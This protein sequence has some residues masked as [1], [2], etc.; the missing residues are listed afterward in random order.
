MRKED[1]YKNKELFWKCFFELAKKE[2]N[3][4]IWGIK[5]PKNKFPDIKT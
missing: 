2:T 1:L 3:E 4:L 5:I